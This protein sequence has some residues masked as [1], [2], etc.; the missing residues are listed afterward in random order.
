M[1]AFF[2]RILAFFF[3]FPYAVWASA[4]S[5]FCIVSDTLAITCY[6]YLRDS[7]YCFRSPCIPILCYD[8]TTL[9]PVQHYEKRLHETFKQTDN[10]STSMPLGPKHVRR[11]AMGEIYQPDTTV[12]SVLIT[13]WENGCKTFRET[14][15]IHRKRFTD[16]VYWYGSKFALLGQ[17][18]ALLSQRGR[19]MLRVYSFYT[20]EWCGYPMV[21]K[22]EHMFI[23]FDM[24]H[25]REKIA[26]FTYRSPHF[27]FPWRRPCD[28]HA[29]CCMNGKTIQ[30]CITPRSMYPS[31]F[32]SFRVKRCLSQCVSPQIAIF[33]TFWFPLGTPLGQSR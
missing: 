5:G 23:R 14:V 4:S 19:A 29:I 8:V 3:C 7:R 25:E 15:E 31:I 21:N 12:V 28:Y 30:C 13:L 33:T 9:F 20:L 10:G 1:E 24:I 16:H 27:C 6:Y 2:H 11:G 17:Q 18:E 32:N 22:F 26:V